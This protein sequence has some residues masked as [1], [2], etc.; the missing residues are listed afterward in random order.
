M[1]DGSKVA[2]AIG[3]EIIIEAAAIRDYI[4]DV[5]NVPRRRNALRRP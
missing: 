2:E 4:G 3:A 5:Q 1:V